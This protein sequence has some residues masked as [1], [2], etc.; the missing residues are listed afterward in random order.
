MFPLFKKSSNL[1]YK[2]PPGGA[3]FIEEAEISIKIFKYFTR[4]KRVS[5][6]YKEVVFR[7]FKELFTDIITGAIEPL[8]II[9][10]KTIKKAAIFE[11]FRE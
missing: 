7:G 4:N 9:E 6:R 8:L 5:R 1:V 2:T 3:N 10:L 11:N